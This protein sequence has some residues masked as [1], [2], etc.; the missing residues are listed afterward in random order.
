MLRL[1]KSYKIWS[2]SIVHTEMRLHCLGSRA[3][4]VWY[5]LYSLHGKSFCRAH[6]DALFVQD[7]PTRLHILIHHSDF[8]DSAICALF[9]ILH[10]YT[11]L[12]LINHVLMQLI[13]I[14]N[15]LL[16][17]KLVRYSSAAQSESV[18]VKVVKLLRR[19]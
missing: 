6:C 16:M 18:E 12:S 10:V 5:L 14:S 11:A 7:K 17:Q 2:R 13:C 1:Q 15:L 8:C 9:D 3:T 4:S 19:Q